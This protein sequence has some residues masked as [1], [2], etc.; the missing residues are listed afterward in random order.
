LRLV[1]SD[2]EARLRKADAGTLRAIARAACEFAVA[3]AGLE[4]PVLKAALA[5]LRSGQR[6]SPPL[7]Q[8]VEAVVNQLDDHALSIQDAVEVGEAKESSYEEAFSRARA[9]SAVQYAFQDDPLMAAAD[10]LYEAHAATGDLGSLRDL[11]SRAL[12]E[13]SQQARNGGQEQA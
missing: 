7:A 13:G 2:L 9:A 8:Q 1:D 3:R 4:D 11:V 10:A 5:V 6:P 12:N